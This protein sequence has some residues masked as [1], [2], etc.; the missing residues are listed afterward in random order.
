MYAVHAASENC[1]AWR[2]AGCH[3]GATLAAARHARYRRC[4]RRYSWRCLRA[5]YGAYRQAAA[6]E[7]VV[8]AGN[9]SMTKA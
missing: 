5:A 8:A 6:V 7:G 2:A 1:A 9:G 4:G 3:C